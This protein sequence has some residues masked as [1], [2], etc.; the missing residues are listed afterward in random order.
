MKSRKP[1]MIPLDSFWK[2]SQD[3]APGPT[4]SRVLLRNFTVREVREA[5]K[6]VS[7]IKKIRVAGTDRGMRVVE[8]IHTC[9]RDR[10]CTSGLSA[11]LSILRRRAAV[12]RKVS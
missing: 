6:G 2:P 11:A 7:G 8:V 12:K 10:H 1:P 9:H 4:G 5:L 3:R